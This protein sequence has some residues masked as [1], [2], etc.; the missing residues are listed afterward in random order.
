MKP[1]DRL[2]TTE[3]AS[4]QSA[5]D[6]AIVQL[7]VR[8]GV[9]RAVVY[10]VMTRMWQVLTG[11][12]SQLLLILFVPSSARDYYFAFTSMLGLQIFIELGL[13]VVIINLASHEWAKLRLEAGRLAGDE[14]AKWR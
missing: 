10:A 6:S 3:T 9:D 12:V 5:A 2:V 13:H 4:S 14:T 7:A 1:D 11:P 8:C